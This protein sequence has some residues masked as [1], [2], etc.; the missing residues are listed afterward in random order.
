MPSGPDLKVSGGPLRFTI[1]RNM[2]SAPSA[3]FRALTA[4]F[5]RWFAVPGTVEMRAAVGAPFYFATEFGGQRHPH[6]GR[7]LTLETNAVVELTW[8]TAASHGVETVV[9]VELRPREEGC[10]LRLTH[11]GFPDE[12]TRSRHE[13]AWPRVLEHM[14]EVVSAT[15]STSPR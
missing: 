5:D 15:A 6:Y 14:D 13:A 7:F 1:E 4:E 8:V 2:N 3:L 9:R 11:S 10:R 12:A